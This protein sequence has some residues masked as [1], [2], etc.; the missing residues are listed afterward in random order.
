MVVQR[1]MPKLIN[2]VRD[3]RSFKEVLMGKNDYKNERTGNAIQRKVIHQEMIHQD[4]KKRT[5]KEGEE[6]RPNNSIFII[7]D[8]CKEKREWFGEKLC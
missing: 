7:E 8:V 5:K 4:V 2:S 3:G 1:S 6:E